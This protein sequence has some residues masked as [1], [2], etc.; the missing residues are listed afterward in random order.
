MNEIINP[1]NTFLNKEKI[2]IGINLYKHLISIDTLR[3][4]KF[5][6][7]IS[8]RYFYQNDSALMIVKDYLNNLKMKF[9]LLL[10]PKG[11]SPLENLNKF[12]EMKFDEENN[13][14]LIITL[15]YDGISEIGKQ[16]SILLHSGVMKSLLCISSIKDVTTSKIKYCCQFIPFSVKIVPK[17][18][19]DFSNDNIDNCE[20]VSEFYLFL[21]DLINRII[22]ISLIYDTCSSDSDLFSSWISIIYSLLVP[23]YLQPE[24]PNKEAARKIKVLLN[25]INK[26]PYSNYNSIILYIFSITI[27]W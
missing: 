26:S 12:K 8:N 7:I 5:A 21:M 9:Q 6:L 24:K 18:L 3:H 4:F 27:Y 16:M 19:V 23:L 15:G 14:I 1:S 13:K 20:S 2:W 22:E 11:F 10:I 17:S 25:I